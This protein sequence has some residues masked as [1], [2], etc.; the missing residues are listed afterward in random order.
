MNPQ[1]EKSSDEMHCDAN[2]DRRAALPPQIWKN[3]TE[4]PASVNTVSSVRHHNLGVHPASV[5][6]VSHLDLPVMASV[7]PVIAAPF[8]SPKS[9]VIY[10]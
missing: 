4:H 7:S 10:G 6:T 1:G 2:K 5:S 8:H 9:G 3:H